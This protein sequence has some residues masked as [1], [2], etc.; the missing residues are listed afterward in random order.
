MTEAQH[1][2]SHLSFQR[3]LSGWAHLELRPATSELSLRLLRPCTSSQVWLWA[4][5]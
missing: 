2:C 3:I 1:G 5:F 4:T